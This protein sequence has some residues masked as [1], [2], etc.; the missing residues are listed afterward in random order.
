M[1]CSARSRRKWSRRA[2]RC[3]SKLFLRSY[4]TGIVNN[5][6]R[7]NF[8]RFVR[9]E[10]VVLYAILDIL[11]AIAF[12]VYFCVFPKAAGVSMLPF[13][14]NYKFYILGMTMRMICSLIGFVGALRRRVRTTRY[15]FYSLPV[16]VMC[17]LFLAIPFFSQE[18]VCTTFEQCEVVVAYN[19]EMINT[20]PKP[21]VLL[22][23]P[24]EGKVFDPMNWSD[25]VEDVLTQTKWTYKAEEAEVTWTNLV[26][27]RCTC[28]G[29]PMSRKSCLFRLK[30]DETV[31]PWCLV[32]PTISKCPA[33]DLKLVTG[34]S[35]ERYHWTKDICQP[36][37]GSSCR[38]SHK[39]MQATKDLIAYLPDHLKGNGDRAPAIG[40]GCRKWKTTDL[41]KWCFVGFDSACVDKE[42]YFLRP[43]DLADRGTSFGLK[44]PA[45]IF[46][47]RS[48]SACQGELREN[49]MKVCRMIRNTACAVVFWLVTAPLPLAAVIYLWLQNRC[50]DL[51]D[52]REQFNV[53]FSESEDSDDFS[54]DSA[55]EAEEVKTQK[56][57]SSEGKSS[58]GR[59]DKRSGGAKA[60]KAAKEGKAMGGVDTPAAHSSGSVM[61]E[62]YSAQHV[63]IELGEWGVPISESAESFSPSAEHVE[64]LATSMVV[65]AAPEPDA[66]LGPSVSSAAAL[67]RPL[68]R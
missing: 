44:D 55:E 48:Y 15:Y 19:R 30:E 64:A 9:K 13:V 17:G 67:R 39:A 22:E 36:R 68:T 3:F 8:G 66:G 62:R 26:K 38:C 45:D 5:H 31:E 7:R 40:G 32:R 4:Y 51:F 21:E 35:G 23:P 56:T 57:I 60:K 37:E 10:T 63:A 50:G 59:K 29:D 6:F 46:Q 43:S 42:S 28:A 58:S 2:R 27:G 53:E 52:F 41:A 34:E 65:E 25:L 47:W 14:P 49:T 54:V 11:I 18:C 1:C 12:I 16:A 61:S 20:V 33:S 24:P